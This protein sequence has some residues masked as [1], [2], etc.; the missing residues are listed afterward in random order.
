MRSSAYSPFDDPAEV[1]GP[2]LQVDLYAAVE[3]ELPGRVPELRL[4]ALRRVEPY[5]RARPRRVAKRKVHQRV[6]SP[7]RQLQ[8]LKFS[9]RSEVALLDTVLHRTV[10]L[11]AGKR[12]SS[13]LS[14]DPNGLASV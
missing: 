4:H 10:E 3:E 6:G 11:P 7:L 12:T 13:L 8:D 9:P 2:A 5:D 14:L 1:D